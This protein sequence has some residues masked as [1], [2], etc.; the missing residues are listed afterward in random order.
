MR[1]LTLCLL[2]AACASSPEGPDATPT[3]PKPRSA[4]TIFDRLHD[5]AGPVAGLAGFSIVHV[6]DAT[7]C[8]GIATTLVRANDGP[9]ATTDQALVAFLEMQFVA[10]LDFSAPTRAQSKDRFEAWLADMTQRAD[11]ALDVYRDQLGS[12]GSDSTKVVGLARTAQIRR[13]FASTLVRSEIPADVRTGEHVDDKTGAYCDAI[14][15]AALPLL[16]KAD[17]AATACAEVATKLA[18][19]WWS[20]VCV[21]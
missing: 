7:R 19:G 3:T 21:H 16:D 10:D 4:V 14:A 6:P 12:S 9:V 17:E 18:P 8:G 5:G 13:H 11:A 20:S 2:L 1:N 15:A